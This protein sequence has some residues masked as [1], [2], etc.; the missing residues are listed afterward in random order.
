MARAHRCSWQG[1]EDLVQT[2]I[3]EPAGEGG[4]GDAGL[5]EGGKT[6]WTEEVMLTALP[7]PHGHLALVLRSL[8]SSQ[9]LTQYTWGKDHPWCALH[10]HPFLPHPCKRE[11]PGEEGLPGA[12]ASA[13]S[14]L[15]KPRFSAHGVA[16]VRSQQSLMQENGFFYIDI[17]QPCPSYTLVGKGFV[18][19]NA[20][21]LDPLC[22]KRL[23]IVSL[24]TNHASLGRNTSHTFCGSHTRS[25]MEA[26]TRA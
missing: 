6:C 24:S 8:I 11:Q 9:R 16:Q 12:A 13:N 5:P 1:K 7:A 22:R 2:V 19:Q 10:S 14:G 18:P 20:I 17:V 3:C 26:W 23:L 21:Q 15:K 25:G 4:R